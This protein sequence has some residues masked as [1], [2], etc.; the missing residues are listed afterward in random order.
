M[1]SGG[2]REMDLSA[3]RPGVLARIIRA[4]QG[5]GDRAE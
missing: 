2:P 4:V 1:R 3:E 5:S